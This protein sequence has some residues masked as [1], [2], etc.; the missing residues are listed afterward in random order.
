MFYGLKK[1]KNNKKNIIAVYKSA[2]FHTI[3][4][5]NWNVINNIFRSLKNVI[6]SYPTAMKKI[7][8]GYIDFTAFRTNVSI[9][10]ILHPSV[11]LYLNV[12]SFLIKKIRNSI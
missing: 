6:H 9:K 10:M 5:T 7:N 4:I 1:K 3:D 2:F 8:E 12:T 11:N